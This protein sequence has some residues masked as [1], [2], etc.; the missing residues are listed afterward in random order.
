V[1]EA[2]K[3]LARLAR[4]DSLERVLRRELEALAPEAEAWARAEGDERA[5]RAAEALRRRCTSP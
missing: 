1:E 5:R 3:V 4:I 2:R